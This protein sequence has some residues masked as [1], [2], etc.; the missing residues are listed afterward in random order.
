[1][2]SSVGIRRFSYPSVTFVG[3]RRVK[4]N[5]SSDGMGRTFYNLL[6]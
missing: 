2:F 6:S 3:I 5:V 1:M 4:L